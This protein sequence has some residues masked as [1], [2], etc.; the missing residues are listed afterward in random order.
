[1]KVAGNFAAHFGKERSKLEAYA[2]VTMGH[3]LS[4]EAWSGQY[5]LR[6][7]GYKH[8]NR[9]CNFVPHLA[10]NLPALVNV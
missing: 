7:G 6:L 9:P 8:T 2:D 4:A 1:M 10:K 5:L 3:A